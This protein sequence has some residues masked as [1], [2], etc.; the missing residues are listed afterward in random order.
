MTGPARPDS[1]TLI[2][3]KVHQSANFAW[4][5]NAM[6]L[7][8]KFFGALSSLLLVVLFFASSP[9]AAN[10]SL[11]LGDGVVLSFADGNI[12]VRTGSGELEGVVVTC[13]LYTSPSPRD[14][15]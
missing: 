7:K 11:Q 3:G 12:D 1:L 5:F 15:A 14:T 6:T 2:W 9:I 13:L 8:A 10:T 4:K